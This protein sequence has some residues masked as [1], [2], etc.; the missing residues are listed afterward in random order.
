MTEPINNEEER[1]AETGTQPNPVLGIMYY[2]MAVHNGEESAHLHFMENEAGLAKLTMD[3]VADT[4]AYQDIFHDG[5]VNIPS[6]A[7]RDP[8]NY[9]RKVRKL[10][11]YEDNDDI[12]IKHFDP[13]Y[14]EESSSTDLSNLD[15]D[16]SDESPLSSD[17]TN[18][19]G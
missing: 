10:F 13:A 12:Y 9:H 4:S 16:I 14:R 7:I 17:L 5:W 8:N 15:S 3:E 1:Y 11:N 6:Q 2:I 19:T 18:L